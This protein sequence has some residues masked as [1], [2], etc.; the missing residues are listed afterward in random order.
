M[1]LLFI[2]ALSNIW[3]SP[4]FS[5]QLST[6]VATSAFQKVDRGTYR[7]KC[8]P[9]SE[10]QNMPRYRNIGSWGLCGAE[11]S[12]NCVQW[13]V[14]KEKKIP[15]CTNL[16]PEDEVS[17]LSMQAWTWVTTN[18]PKL[19]GDSLLHRNLNILAYD[20]NKNPV[21]KG[22]FGSLALSNSKREFSFHSEACYPFDQ[23]ANT[24]KFPSEAAAISALV[25]A[26]KFYEENKKMTEGFCE[27]C[28]T[29]EIGNNF[30]I[31]YNRSRVANALKSDTFK[32]FLFEL[33][34][35]GCRKKVSAK[36]PIFSAF[37]PIPEGDDPHANTGKFKKNDLDKK[38]TDILT[39]QKAPINLDGICIVKDKSKN[40]KCI[41]HAAAISGFDKVCKNE[42]CT[43]CRD[44]IKIHNSWGADWQ[45]DYTDDG[46]VDRQSLIDSIKD[47]IEPATL[48]WIY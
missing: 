28:F 15:D 7:Y 45:K 43:D 35:A 26:E 33:V 32:Q 48:T 1:R 21:F 25:K 4:S 22:T 34:Y 5:Q 27:D 3:S 29:T 18:N 30:G 44:R 10:V 47:P 13:Y 41:F 40:N 42:N 16:K 23:L 24:N 19:Y 31:E 6:L 11:S 17:V 20:D 8:G 39:D 38:I 9:S 14:C 37:P 2:L 46:Y 36:P 12:K